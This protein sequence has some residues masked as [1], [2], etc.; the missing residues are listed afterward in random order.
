MTPLQKETLTELR[1]ALKDRP[2]KAYVTVR[3]GDVA[4]VAKLVAKE[5]L[6][7]NALIVATAVAGLGPDT[8]VHLACHHLLELLDAVGPEGK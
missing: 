2:A 1:A 8:E 5:K 7:G 3:A 4:E 6:A